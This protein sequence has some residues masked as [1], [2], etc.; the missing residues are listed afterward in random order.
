VKLSQRGVCHDFA[1]C[2]PGG[3]VP[4]AH[5]SMMHYVKI[6]DRN[7]LWLNNLTLLTVAFMPFPTSLLSKHYSDP[8]AILVYCATLSTCNLMG[9]L[10]W[11][12]VSKNKR[13]V[14]ENL[15]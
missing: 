10:F 2:N 6:I 7:A 5:H 12:Y 1:A 3:I 11:L 4:G 9:S 14:D 8:L 15:S 13:L